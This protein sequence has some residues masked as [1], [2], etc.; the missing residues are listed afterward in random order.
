MRAATKTKLTVEHRWEDALHFFRSRGT[1]V[2]I[3]YC[4][5]WEKHGFVQQSLARLLSENGVKVIWID[6]AW[7]GKHDPV[8]PFANRNLDVRYLH[9]LPGRRFDA[10]AKLSNEYLAKQVKQVLIQEKN[11]LVWVQAGLEPSLAR[12]IPYVDVLSTFDDPYRFEYAELARKANLVLCQNTFTYDRLTRGKDATTKARYQVALPPIDLSPGVFDEKSELE[13]PKNFPK[14]VMGYIGSSFPQDFDF[15]LLEYFVKNLPEW[16]ILLMGRTNAI[17][18]ERIRSL[19]THKN[20]YYQPW[21]PRSQVAA[22]WK[23]LSVSLLLYRP[24]GPQDGAF[25]VKAVESAYFG[26]PCVATRVHKTQDLE[27][28]FPRTSLPD[29]MVEEALEA[30]RLSKTRV[31]QIF[32]RLSV[33]TDPKLH[34][35]RVAETL[36]KA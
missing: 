3:S 13:L 8:V 7:T 22:A 27:G 26:V 36:H 9:Q 17:G 10:V 16:G 24:Y 32:S 23:K 19:Q 28:I 33:Q 31:A 29:L 15:N 21:M 4:T 18:Q 25:P 30:T 34:L 12:A 5:F 35:I 11:P 20:F 6:G 2:F 14:R 1:V